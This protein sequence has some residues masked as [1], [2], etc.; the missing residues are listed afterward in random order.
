MT[1][2]P[3]GSSGHRA[4]EQYRISLVTETGL[5]CVMIPKPTSG[6]SVANMPF[7]QRS[8]SAAPEQGAAQI[9][10]RMKNER[11]CI[12]LLM[13]SVATSAMGRAQDGVGSHDILLPVDQTPRLRCDPPGVGIGES[14]R[15]RG[16][17]RRQPRFPCPGSVACL[18]QIK[19]AP[20]PN[21]PQ[22]RKS[23]SKIK[24][25]TPADLQ[26]VSPYSGLKCQTIPNCSAIALR[27]PNALANLFGR[28]P[29]SPTLLAKRKVAGGAATPRSDQFN[30]SA[31]ILRFYGIAD[32]GASIVSQGGGA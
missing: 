6:L 7:V 1:F 5:P 4:F 29:G 23:P 2:R 25:M 32:S 12:Q 21:R 22:R 8:S 17:E 27:V 3:E 20:G 31:T 11:K 9:A 19:A 10:R 13:S 24:L 15:D 28:P 18:G 14:A 26:Q 30:S 16:M